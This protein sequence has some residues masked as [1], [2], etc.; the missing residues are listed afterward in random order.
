MSGLDFVVKRV[1]FAL[2]TVFTT[3]T[4][5][6]VLFRALPGDA[7]ANLS[8]VPNAGPELRQ[9]LTAQFGL[10][11]PKWQQY[12]IYLRELLH[13]NMGVS[14]ADQEPVTGKLG[15]ALL[16]TLPMVTC[17][18]LLA[19]LIG[20]ATGVLAAWRHDGLTDRLITQTSIACYSLPTQWLALLLL[21]GFAGILP[22]AGM[23]DPFV[24]GPRSFADS[25]TDVIRHMA[26]PSLTLALTLYG[27]YTLVVRSSM[28]E[29]LSEDYVLTARAKGLPPRTIIAR[30]VLRNSMLPTMTLIAMSLGFIVAGAVLVEYVFSWPG[31]GKAVVDA[32]QQR[33]YPMLQ[34]TFLVLTLSVVAF[35]LAADLLY[36]RLDPRVS[37]S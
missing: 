18:T 16:N 23:V 36:A 31:V 5:N 19:I 24:V 37:G 8:R 22:V 30:H 3:I 17:G 21:I 10:D 29:S 34:G 32:V 14:Y 11:K 35:N 27:E 2:A 20:T 15:R 28:L 13:G 4:L 25:A 9:A 7:V 6:F 33:D 26:L 12:L 1:G